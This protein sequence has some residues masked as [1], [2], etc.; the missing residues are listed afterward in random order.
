MTQSPKR[1]LLRPVA[2]VLLL[3][4]ALNGCYSYVPSRTGIG[5]PGSRVRVYLTEPQS[6]RLTEI[7]ANDVVRITG[8]VVR[9]DSSDLVLSAWLLNSRS[10]YEH[11]GRGETVAVP[12]RNVQAVDRNTLSAVRTAG[13]VGIVAMLGVLTGVALANGASR[14]EGPPGGGNPQ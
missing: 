1:V 8:E 6:V 13:L 2:T 3:A 4:S 11:V 12:R 7:S 5:G 14:G 9:A 10:G